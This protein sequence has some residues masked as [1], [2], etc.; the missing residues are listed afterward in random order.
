MVRRGEIAKREYRGQ[1]S[2]ESIEEFVSKQLINPVKDIFNMNEIT[3]FD[4]RIF[5][6]PPYLPPYHPPIT[7]ISP[8]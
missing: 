8:Y 6:S 5:P 4:V 7:P 3:S 2:V 1:R